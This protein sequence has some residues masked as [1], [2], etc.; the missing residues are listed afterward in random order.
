MKVGVF[1]AITHKAWLALLG[2]ASFASMR[3]LFWFSCK[4]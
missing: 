3:K 4:S 1:G 2:K